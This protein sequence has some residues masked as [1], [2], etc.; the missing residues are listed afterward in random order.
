VVH[1]QF[2]TDTARYAD[3]VLPATMQIETD[4]VVL[5]WGHLWIGWNEAAIDPPGETCSNTEMFRRVARAMGYTE[6][7]LFDDDHTLLRD[8][9]PTIDLDELVGRLGARPVSRRRA[10]VRRRRFDTP[11]GRVQLASEQLE[12]MGQPRVPTYVPPREGPGGDP[13]LVERYPLQLL[14][15]KHHT[16]FL[17]SSYSDLPK[18]GPAEGGPFV[19]LDAADAGAR[20]LVEG[21][22]ARVWNDRASVIVPVRI[23]RSA[24]ARRGGDP[25][26]LVEPPPSRRPDRQQPH[27]RHAHRVGRRRGLQRHPRPGE[28]RRPT[29]APTSLGSLRPWPPT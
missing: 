8:A 19:E 18:H 25:V 20:G 15:P 27:Q 17:N 11:S 4:D 5:P 28:R 24:P 3:I 6:P 16:R 26:R 2:L 29:W 14:T 22:M 10:P 9:L 7:S 13:E 23:T 12:R 1:E 21:A